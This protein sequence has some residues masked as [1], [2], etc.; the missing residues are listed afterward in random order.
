MAWQEPETVTGSHYA[1]DKNGE[2][3]VPV[4]VKGGKPQERVESV[5][6]AT[7]LGMSAVPGRRSG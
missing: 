2:P 5:R 6:S 4:I 3:R 1:Q 7:G